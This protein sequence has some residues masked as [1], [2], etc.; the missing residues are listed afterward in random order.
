MPD[1]SGPSAEQFAREGYLV[2]RAL[3]GESRCAA[4]VEH[5]RKLALVGILSRPDEQ[6]PQSPA[7]Y[8]EPVVEEM[9]EEL[10]PAI[11]R[12]V[13]L[14]LLPTYSYVRLYKPGAALARH[15]DRE[16]CEI[17]L[18]LSLGARPAGEWPIWIEGYRG[19][20]AVRLQ[21]GDALVYRGIDCAHWRE[22]FT[23]EFA[24]QAFLHYVDRNGPHRDLKFD[25]RKALNT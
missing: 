21:P 8:A 1:T 25:K 12:I 19:T 15:Q 10:R 7:M 24:V 6:V 9:L 18:T 4:V 2:A 22:P 17:S 3:V 11:E 20:E 13:G 23:G 14:A 16:A 5:L